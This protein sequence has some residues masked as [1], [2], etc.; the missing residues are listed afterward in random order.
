MARSQD[1]YF[2]RLPGDIKPIDCLG[3]LHGSKKSPPQCC[4]GCKL[5]SGNLIGNRG[6]Y[7]ATD[8]TKT[9]V[10]PRRRMPP[11]GRKEVKVF[12]ALTQKLA[13]KTLCV[14]RRSGKRGWWG[15]W[16]TVLLLISTFEEIWNHFKRER[17][18]GKREG[19]I[20]VIRC[21]NLGN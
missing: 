3:W 21:Y 11:K 12:L 17:E 10:Q 7:C 18:G 19:E 13:T 15:I 1:E 16:V 20:Q 9:R 4:A 6:C 2:I 8:M 5:L 14:C